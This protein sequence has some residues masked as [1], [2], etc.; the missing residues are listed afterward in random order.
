MKVH[1][2][3]TFPFC[4]DGVNTVMAE[5]GKS[6]DIPTELYPGLKA[7]GFVGNVVMDQK[8]AGGAP[9][10]K[11][12]GASPENK[13]AKPKWL[14]AFDPA[15][16][17]MKFFAQ[18]AMAIKV[19]GRD[20]ADSAEVTAVLEAAEK[21]VAEIELQSEKVAEGDGVEKTGIE[22]PAD[23]VMREAELGNPGDP[24]APPADQAPAA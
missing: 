3:K 18:K 22:T 16:R 19:A 13:D 14:E 5:A 1:A 12:A 15:W 21:K 2:L 10:N 4:P 11:D 8:D 23:G 24:L 6:A 20:V 9:E 7:A 17:K